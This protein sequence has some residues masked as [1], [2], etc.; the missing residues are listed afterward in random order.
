MAWSKEQL[1]VA[2]TIIR[3]G[4]SLGASNR[5]IITALMAGIV[6]SGLR[7]LSYGDRDSVGV[8]QQRNAWG[9][10]E[11]R[12]NV[13]E[14][15]RM[16]FQGGHGGQ[17]GLFDIKNRNSMSMGQAAQAVQ[18]SA[19]PDRYDKHA[20]EATKLLGASPKGGSNAIPTGV[21]AG[22]TT[23]SHVSLG[24][25][26]GIDE[27][28]KDSPELRA[29]NDPLGEV[30]AEDGPLGAVGADEAGI[31]EMSMGDED[32]A[33][34]LDAV[35]FDNSGQQLRA[36]TGPSLEEQ[37]QELMEKAEQAGNTT[38]TQT[39]QMDTSGPGGGGGG[40]KGVVGIAKKFLGVPYVWGGTSPSG[41]DCSGFVQYVMRQA[42][43]NLPRISADQARAGKR[44]SLKDLRVGDLVAWDNS[45][46]NNGADHI[47]IY[48]G[49]GK[50]IHAPRPGS[51]VRIDGIFDAGRAWGV[52]L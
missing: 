24:D 18:V 30:G 38:S 19:F 51:S 37:I 13:A 7:N 46:R 9:S 42:G 45:S 26:P 35:S 16:F 4:K 48:I 3:V 27:L 15:A 23:T 47:A 25:I 14:S 31:G 33:G 5:D 49:G 6:E 32:M 44:I 20:D 41:F 50:I 17:R 39:W 11:Q 52:R 12:T 1:G 21:Q 34:P 40:N 43:V 29:V 8:F 36:Q 22:G 10:F 2:S 28:M